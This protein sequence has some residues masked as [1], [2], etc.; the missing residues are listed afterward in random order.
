MII[1]LVPISFK[2]LTPF[3][4]ASI[5]APLADPEKIYAMQMLSFLALVD[6]L[7]IPPMPATPLWC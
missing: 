7:T 1:S 5:S 6:L 2:S 3:S 4:K